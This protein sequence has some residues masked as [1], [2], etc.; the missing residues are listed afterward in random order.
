MWGRW[1][2]NDHQLSDEYLSTSTT[3]LLFKAQIIMT[4]RVV[5]RIRPAQKHEL[6]KDTILKAASIGNDPPTLIKIRNPKNEQELFTFQFSSVYDEAAEQQTI[7]DAESMSRSL[8][9]YT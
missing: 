8:C 9:H 3:P 1:S 4:I 2:G 7:F 6:E 5:A